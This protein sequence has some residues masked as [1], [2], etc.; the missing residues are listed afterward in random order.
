[1]SIQKQSLTAIAVVWIMVTPAFADQ[2]LLPWPDVSNDPAP[3]YG[4][5][6]P[7]QSQPFW[8]RA[9]DWRGFYV[10]GQFGY[11]DASA[12]FTNSTQAPIAYSLREAT[13][14]SE[15]APS[16]WPVLGTAS[17]GA[18]G[19]GGFVGYNTEYVSEYAKVVL[20]L[21]ANYD[22]AM[23]S[24]VAPNSPISRITPDNSYGVD[25]TGSGTVTDLNFGTLRARVGWALGNFLPYAFAGVAIGSANVN[26]A[27]TTVLEQNPP[28]SGACTTLR[29]PPCSIF[30]FP[31]TAGK[32]GEWMYGGT[33]GAGLDVALTRNIFVRGEYEFVQFSSVAGM[34]VQV[35]TVRIGAGIKF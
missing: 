7:P 34:S 1:V 9:M 12:D 8:P 21:E 23:L 16:D 2:L 4:Y 11:S 31:G 5:A 25:I 22:Q 3:A 20:G 28:S 24:V 27:E 26:I 33:V 10:G 35:N 13:V 18:T 14:E 19:F 15:F 29:S 17:H 6:Q 32:D 30:T